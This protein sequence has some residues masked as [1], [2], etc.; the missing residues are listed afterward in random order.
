MSV[1]ID[2][3]PETERRLREKAAKAGQTIEDHL[4]QLAEESAG[5]AR[6][7]SEPST[8]PAD[9]T[10]EERVAEWLAW[11]ASHRD[12]TLVADDSRESIYA[13]RGE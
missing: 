2:L 5:S 13:G 11:V 4:R 3:A 7:A 9:R 12:Q 10:P 8:G 6:G 1:T